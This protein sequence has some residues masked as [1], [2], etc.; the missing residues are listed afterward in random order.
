MMPQ[1]SSTDITS[2]FNTNWY[3]IDN[4]K[5]HTSI[6]NHTLIDTSNDVVDNDMERLYRGS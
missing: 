5:G 2:T 1:H 3:F 6:P 4:D